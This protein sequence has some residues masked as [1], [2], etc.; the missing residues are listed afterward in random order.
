MLDVSLVATDDRDDLC[1]F[2]TGSV[3]SESVENERWI[4]A[5]A[6]ARL[7]LNSSSWPIWDGQYSFRGCGG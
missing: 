1:P 6:F 4:A 5:S 2:T 7:S 3:F